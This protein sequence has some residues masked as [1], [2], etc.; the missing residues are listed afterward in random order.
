MQSLQSK[1]RPML[2]N[3][4]YKKI[5]KLSSHTIRQA[6]IGKV[7]N[8]VSS[9][10]NSIEYKLHGLVQMMVAPFTLTVGCYVLV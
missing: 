5:S 1:I 3:V 8:I 4:I 7:I 10:L 2:A 9:D 6:N